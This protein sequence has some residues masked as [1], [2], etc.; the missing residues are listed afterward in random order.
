MC[1]VTLS[2]QP[3]FVSAEDNAQLSVISAN[4][5]GLPSIFSKYD[6]DVSYSQKTLGKMLNDSGYDIVCVQEDFQYH[7]VLASEMTSYPYQTHE[8]GGVPIGDGL[9]IFSVYPIYNVKRVAWNKYYG[10]FSDGSDALCPKGFICCTVDVDGAL[11]DLYNVHMDA[12]SAEGDQYARKAQLEQLT[13]Y[14]SEN[15][16]GRAVLI[17]GDTNLT[18]HKDPLVEAHRILIEEAKFTD[19]WIEIKNGGNYMQGSDGA[20]LIKSWYDKF[21]GHD[22]GRWDSVERVL[23][24]SGGGIVFEPKHFEYVIYTDDKS[25]IKSLTDHRIMECVIDLDLSSY[26]RPTDIVLNAPSEQT[27]ILRLIRDGSMLIRAFAILLYGSILYLASNYP[28]VLVISVA[29]IFAHFIILFIFMKKR[30]RK[31]IPGDA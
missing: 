16:E 11:I 18:F 20:A 24:R 13:E 9:N 31:R 10:I 14:I 28:L 21:G 25:N 7:S 22:W 29:F 12:Y 19:C 8:T 30:K 3:I 1:C 26:Q 23:Y 2:M 6:R 27:M 5:S 17:V 4:V 15:S